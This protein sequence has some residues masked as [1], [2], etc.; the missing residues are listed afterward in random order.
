LYSTIRQ[1]KPTCAELKQKRILS[2]IRSS[3]TTEA[4][5]VWFVGLL[6]IISWH[7]HHHLAR[8]SSAGTVI[9]SWYGH[10]QLARSSSAG[11]VII[12][13]HG[14]HQPARSLLAGT[15]II[16][17]HGHRRLARWSSLALAPIATPTPMNMAP[18]TPRQPNVSPRSRY[19]NPACFG[20]LRGLARVSVRVGLHFIPLTPMK[21]WCLRRS[22]T[23]QRNNG[24]FLPTHINETL[25][26]NQTSVIIGNS[27]R[28]ECGNRLR[29]AGPLN[30]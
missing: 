4:R 28:C 17:W 25:V 3:G 5:S 20:M 23:Y 27:K 15:V 29:R 12:N 26:P 16:S 18:A 7:G 21:Q 30:R 22:N 11:T 10:H 14:Y 6:V 13:W 24:V 9:V 1:Y 8:L 19:E 2:D